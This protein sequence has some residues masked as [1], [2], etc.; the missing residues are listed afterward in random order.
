VGAGSHDL[1]MMK[2]IAFA[3][4]IIMYPIEA[5]MRM[6]I[7]M[8]KKPTAYVSF[9][10]HIYLSEFIAWHQKLITTKNRG[11]WQ[12]EVVDENDGRKRDVMYRP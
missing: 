7:A 8:K 1:M 5:M 6:M 9:V 3:I 4:C 12:Q 10:I 2:A 11:T